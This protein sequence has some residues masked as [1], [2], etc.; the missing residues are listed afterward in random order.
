MIESW[1]SATKIPRR[2]IAIRPRTNAGRTG[3]VHTEHHL[4][5]FC[6]MVV[7]F[8]Y[9]ETRSTAENHGRLWKQLRKWKWRYWQNDQDEGS[10][11]CRREAIWNVEI[12]EV[13][14]ELNPHIRCP[15]WWCGM[16]EQ[17]RWLIMH[18][19]LY[20]RL[21]VG[22]VISLMAGQLSC[23]VRSDILLLTCII[24]SAPSSG[25]ELDE[26]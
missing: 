15:R 21:V 7:P 14:C 23:Q 5:L 2:I 12:Q 3:E 1:N 16:S 8:R 26:P 17:R 11:V 19:M 22:S 4:H 13:D 25:L 10:M 20:E 9:V 18:M 6:R 24:T